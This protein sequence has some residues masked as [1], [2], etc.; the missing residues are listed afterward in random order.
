MTA[1]IYEAWFLPGDPTRQE[2]SISASEAKATGATIIIKGLAREFHVKY[3]NRWGDDLHPWKLR[4]NQP[5]GTKG[6]E[7]NF[8]EINEFSTF[9]SARAEARIMAR[10]S[11]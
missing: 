7:D 3:M 10:G 8:V 6:A 1:G 2:A 5:V 11:R 4:E 9:T